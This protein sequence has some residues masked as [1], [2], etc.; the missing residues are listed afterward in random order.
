MEVAQHVGD[1]HRALHHALPAS[2]GLAR[3]MTVCSPGGARIQ[4]PV[5]EATLGP[6]CSTSSASPSTA[7]TTVTPRCAPSGSIYRQPPSFE[8]QSP[9][10]EILETGIKVIDLLE[11]YPK[12]GKIGLFGGAGVGKTVLIQELIHNVATEH[13]GYSIFTGVGE[14]S[15][16]GNDLWREMRESGVSDKTALVFGQ[17]NESAR[18]AYARGAV[19]A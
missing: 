4:V 18:R 15:R 16:E 17:M 14:R 2:D 8:E 7:A 5:G 9:A 11:P 6:R 12:G 3:G 10:V 1:E 19:R 13:G